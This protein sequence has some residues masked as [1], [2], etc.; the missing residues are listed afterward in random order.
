MTTLARLGRRVASEQDATLR[1]LD[2]DLA[3]VRDR[4]VQRTARGKPQLNRRALVVRAAFATTAFAAAAAMTL[5]LLRPRPL[6][7][8]VGTSDGALGVWI[9]PS[10]AGTLPITFSDGTT[11]ALEPES[12]ARVVK[13]EHEGATVVLERGRAHASVIHTGSAQWHLGAGPFDV[14]VTGTRF[15]LEWDPS[16]EN[17]TLALLEGSVVV[18]G[19][20]LGGG[21]RV[22]TG[23]TLHVAARDL[24][25]VA[26]VPEVAH[27][28]AKDLKPAP[29]TGSIAPTRPA[30][31]HREAPSV[32]AKASN[33]VPPALTWRALFGQ[34]RYREALDAA[35]EAGFPQLCDQL[36][37]D[38]LL[39]LGDA[40]RF[41]G[42]SA[43]ASEAY[44]SLRKH[45]PG[46]APAAVAAFAMGR[47]N[48]DQRKSYR[49]AV[50]WF[51][52][53]LRER[54]AGV[55][56]REAS[57]RLIEARKASGDREGA[58][59]AATHYLGTFP[60][61]P[62]AQLAKSILNE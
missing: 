15:D 55:L 36:S 29:Q 14:L 54:P 34:G 52:T 3:E 9:A 28:A 40:A 4:L 25:A 44:L 26:Q 21:R 13:V 47:L 10:G 51:E 33:S 22:V 41:G 12:R 18:S 16:T 17:L 6:S 1:A 32:T 20:V 24:R 60:D 2:Q 62:H 56:A 7:F 27:G 45:Y 19:S 5:Y 42:S 49:E 53:Y 8:H 61:G 43:R 38:D 30:V 57:G 31:G 48:F 11:L 35:E 50:S 46:A 58:R 37:A 39:A 59:T 23:E